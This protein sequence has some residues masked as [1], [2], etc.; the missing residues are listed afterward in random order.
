MVSKAMPN[1]DTMLDTGMLSLLRGTSQV[2]ANQHMHIVSLKQGIL[3]NQMRV[4]AQ[5]LLLMTTTRLLS[6]P[7]PVQLPQLS[8]Q[9]HP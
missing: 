6:P 5:L 2:W 3:H 7:A 8:Q 9:Q 4:L 1:R